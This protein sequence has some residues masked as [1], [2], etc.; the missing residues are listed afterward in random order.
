MRPKSGPDDQ[1]HMRAIMIIFAGC[2]ARAD[3]SLEHAS[4]VRRLTA[5][6]VDCQCSTDG[7]SAGLDTANGEDVVTYRSGGGGG[8]YKFKGCG[9]HT[10]YY[11]STYQ[12]IAGYPFRWC[13]VV[14]PEQFSWEMSDKIVY[15]GTNATRRKCDGHLC[16]ARR[17][18]TIPGSS[19]ESS[20]LGAMADWSDCCKLCNRQRAAA[21]AADGETAGCTA[22]AFNVSES[23]CELSESSDSLDDFPSS[24]SQSY[25][26]LAG[27]D[28]YPLDCRVRNGPYDTCK[29]FSPDISGAAW[30]CLVAGAAL[31]TAFHPCW[32]GSF[33]QPSVITI[34]SRTQSTET[35]VSPAYEDGTGGD[36][37]QATV[38]KTAFTYDRGQR[39]AMVD[40]SFKYVNDPPNTHRDG[41]RDGDLAWQHAHYVG[42]GAPGITK[43]GVI[44]RG[45]WGTCGGHGDST[46]LTVFVILLIS[47]SGCLVPGLCWYAIS[48]D[49]YNTDGGRFMGEFHFGM[50]TRAAGLCGQILSGIW[51]FLFILIPGFY[52]YLYSREAKKRTQSLGEVELPGYAVLGWKNTTVALVPKG[53]P[54]AFVFE[55]ATT[56]AAG[57]P[58]P[59]TLAS[60]PGRT[61]MPKYFQPKYFDLDCAC[62]CYWNCI[63]GLG[64]GGDATQLPA[65]Q[66]TFCTAAFDAAR[67]FVICGT[68]ETDDKKKFIL[69]LLPTN[70]CHTQEHQS[71]NSNTKVAWLMGEKNGQGFRSFVVNADG[72]IGPAKAPHL[73]LGVLGMDDAGRVNDARADVLDVEMAPHYAEKASVVEGR[74]VG[75]R[76]V[77]PLSAGV[78]APPPASET[79]SLAAM[80]QKIKQQLGIAPETPMAQAI[81]EACA[82]LGID[83]NGLNLKE[84]VERC[85]AEV[86]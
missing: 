42:T 49:V 30:K 39:T 50:G 66:R 65:D 69:T 2:V 58:A 55:H 9:A 32:R 25:C 64:L 46:P 45:G 71:D 14:N 22:W 47:L 23:T 81:D 62:N 63:D 80:T 44:S 36:E 1:L 75:V 37:F 18:C 7:F 17:S 56:I 85:F 78:D 73:V 16:E 72:T 28:D 24:S 10:N 29:D 68:G 52:L 34:T 19:F 43:P 53:S 48:R 59:L 13:F 74:V 70:S 79:T 35:R 67:G 60:H 12:Q 54:N 31:L 38:T 26:G 41:P 11:E 61:V 51:S 40:G 21:L 84:K 83:A 33:P 8:K 77:Q 3:E 57:S 27:E 86:S 4:S 76:S 20:V 6:D 15:H 82:A 5:T